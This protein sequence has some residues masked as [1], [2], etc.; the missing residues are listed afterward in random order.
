M[1]RS[2]FTRKFIGNGE[3]SGLNQLITA[4]TRN[5]CFSVSCSSFFPIFVFGNGQ[6]SVAKPQLR[7]A[8]NRYQPLLSARKPKQNDMKGKS[9]FTKSEIVELERL[10]ILRN[11]TQ[12]TDQKAIRQKMRKIGFYGKDDW[13]IN[14]L[15]VSDLN[16][17]IKS[18]RIKISDSEYPSLIIKKEI[19]KPEVKSNPKQISK[20]K[21]DKDEFYVLN[22]C[23]KIL[24]LNSSRQHKFDF[25]LGDKNKN[26][27][28]AKLPVDSFYKE[29]NLVIEYCERQHTESVSFFDKPYKITVSGVHRGEQRKIY[30]QRRRKVLPENNIKLIEISYSDFAFDGQKRIIRNIQADEIIIRNKLKMVLKKL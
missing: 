16:S 9:V 5:C 30:D 4:V 25:L 26:G 28:A 1:E 29:L 22:L 17:L 19:V 23:D 27:N 7:V 14:D 12:A 2:S 6:N 21:I 24:N 8:S 18:G 11:K 20:P 13:G 10:I 3:F 15:K